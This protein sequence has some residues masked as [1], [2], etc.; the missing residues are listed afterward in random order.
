[1]PK[2][3]TTSKNLFEKVDANNVVVNKWAVFG[4]D[5][6]ATY[7]TLCCKPVPIIMVVWSK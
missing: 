6:N 1:M 2:H 7:C 5:A 4:V 3:K